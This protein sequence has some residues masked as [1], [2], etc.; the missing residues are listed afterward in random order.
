M[1][2]AKNVFTIHY[3]KYSEYSKNRVFGYSSVHITKY[4]YQVITIR[5]V[6]VQ[7]IIYQSLITEYR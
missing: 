5:L 7:H 2:F 3:G 4:F 6:Q 1:H